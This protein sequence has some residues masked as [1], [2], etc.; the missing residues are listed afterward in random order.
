M[1]RNAVIVGVDYALPSHEV[2]NEELDAAH[3][4]WRM[5]EVAK[6]TGVK[7]RHLAAPGETALDLGERA[8]RALLDRLAIAPDGIDGLIVC[9]ETPD[10]IMPPN[11]CLLQHRLGLSKTTMAFDYTLAC[12]GY[13]Y[14][15]FMAKSFIGSGAL[16]SILLVTG[17]TYSSL[18]ASGDRGTVTLFGDGV[19][20]TLVR[21]SDAP[22]VGEIVLGTDGG[23]A[24]CFQVP[25]GGARLPRSAETAVIHRD[26]S[27]NER[28]LEHI[29]MNG[30]AVL[31]FVKREVPGNVALVLERAGLTMEQ[32]DLVV[33]HQASQMSFDTLKRA[34]RIPDSKLFINIERLGNTVS[35]S[36]PIALRDAELAG[37]LKPGAKVLL[38]GFGVGLSWG[39]CV[40]QW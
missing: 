14:G 20:A 23:P 2:S 31:E 7:S 22:G 33:C 34:L 9:T 16:T 29:A 18:I 32:I 19:A 24:A 40:L 8:S 39:S 1:K 28:S 12:S 26:S 6:R 21:A 3:P 38:V 10:Q 15:L 13:I 37:A 17:D 27:G 5:R 35:A 30:A 36:I 4:A 11:A 25:A